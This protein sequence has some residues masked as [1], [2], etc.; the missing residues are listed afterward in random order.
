MMTDHLR[1]MG[2]VEVP[3]AEYLARLREACGTQAVFS[4]DPISAFRPA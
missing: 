1:T 3:R 2:A 4:A